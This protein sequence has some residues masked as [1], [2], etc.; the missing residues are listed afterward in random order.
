MI[1]DY[2]TKYNPELS[3]T[4]VTGHDD[5]VIGW[6]FVDSHPVLIYSVAAI[7]DKLV[8][9]DGMEYQDALEF[10]DYNIKQAYVGPTSPI[11]DND[12]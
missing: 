3:F 7:V 10:F 5:A 8:T 9:R 2:I 12:V 4:T 1:L 11:F 6:R